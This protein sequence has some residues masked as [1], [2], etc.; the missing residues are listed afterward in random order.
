MSRSKL[1]VTFALAV[2]LS[3]P[4]FAASPSLQQVQPA[5]LKVARAAGASYSPETRAAAQEVAKGLAVAMVK[6]EVRAQVRDALRASP[7][8]EHRLVLQEL[9]ASPQ[10]SRL[11]DAAAKALRISSQEFKTTVASLPQLDLYVP[12]P[13]HR[14]TWTATS[15]LLVAAGFDRHAHQLLA[16]DLSGNV[17][18]LL[19]QDG[20][21]ASPLMILSPAAKK[22]R[23]TERQARTGDVIEDRQNMNQKLVACDNTEISCDDG[24]GGGTGTTTPPS[25]GYYLT[26]FN[27]QADDGWFDNNLELEFRTYYTVPGV[28]G[29]YQPRTLT[30]SNITGYRGYT[31]NLFMNSYP[32]YGYVPFNAVFAVDVVEMD[33]GGASLNGNDYYGTRYYPPGPTNGS[34][35][36]YTVDGYNVTAYL[37]I[38]Q[39]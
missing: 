5:N 25:P 34:T 35:Y 36:P 2:L 27:I 23:A 1:F 20:T 3:F 15:D 14:T 17:H 18:T 32:N 4:A 37:G 13:E 8:K 28:G 16:Y 24:G 39:R 31:V 30:Q 6:R 26:Y 10:A 33:G 19:L 21:P 29:Y 9:V 12:F 38:T 7:W 22:H 11:V